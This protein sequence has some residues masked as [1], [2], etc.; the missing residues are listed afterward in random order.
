MS[1][2][3]TFRPTGGINAYYEALKRLDEDGELLQLH[4]SAH[5]A[6]DSDQGF[7]VVDVWD[8]EQDFQDFAAVLLPI[9]E[10][11]GLNPGQPEIRTLQNQIAPGVAAL[12]DLGIRAWDEHNAALWADLFAD[13]FEL[14]D[15]S[16]PEPLTTNEGVYQYMSTWFT[17]FPDMRVRQ[18]DRVLSSHRVA[19]FI[20]FTGT[21]TGPLAGPDGTELPITGR[22]VYG[23]GSYTATMDGT[24]HIT[25]FT[26]RPD[27]AGLL[28]QLTAEETGR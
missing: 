15:P 21:H 20:E 11:V 28:A 23:T 22:T 16:L 6:A 13:H 8:S 27:V 3:V 9:L 7:Q 2:V 5:Y 19:G 10:G 26:A 1:I 14:R 25:E 4:R 12:D 17:A 24:G 18:I